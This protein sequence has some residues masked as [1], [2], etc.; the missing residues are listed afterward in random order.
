MML[1]QARNVRELSVRSRPL[2]FRTQQKGTSARPNNTL[3][4]NVVKLSRLPGSPVNT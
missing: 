2:M 1:R 4:S 3:R